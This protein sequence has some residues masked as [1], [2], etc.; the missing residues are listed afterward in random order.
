MLHAFLDAGAR[1]QPPRGPRSHDRPGRPAV[2]RAHAR[3]RLDAALLPCR[4]AGQPQRRRA[5]SSP[6]AASPRRSP[7]T[8]SAAAGRSSRSAICSPSAAST[9]PRSTAR[10]PRSGWL[11]LEDLG[12]DTLANYLLRNDRPRESALSPRRAPIS[13]RAAGARQAARRQHR[14]HARL[15]RRPPPLGDRPLPRVGARSARPPP[16]GRRPRPLRRHRRRA[17]PRASP[18]GRGASSTATTS[19]AT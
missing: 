3:R 2:L 11:L 10:T 17:S 13:P 19:R 14:R 18:T 7:R 1:F 5:C 16:R 4:A 8:A 9:C 12:D 6:R 15:R